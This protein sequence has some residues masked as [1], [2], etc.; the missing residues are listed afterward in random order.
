MEVLKALVGNFWFWIFGL[1]LI[2][3]GAAEMIGAWMKHKERMAMIE[4]GIHPD[5]PQ[6][7]PQ[8]PTRTQDVG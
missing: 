3:W 2:V 1:P 6:P 5:A 7:Q 4:R 8:N